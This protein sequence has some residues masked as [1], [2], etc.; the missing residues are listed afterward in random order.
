MALLF[1]RC[2]PNAKHHTL[3]V[4]NPT[5]VAYNECDEAQSTRRVPRGAGGR[6]GRRRGGN[7]RR[8]G[9][10]GSEQAAADG[11]RLLR[12]A[13]RLREDAD[14]ALRRPLRLRRLRPGRDRDR[15][16]GRHT[17]RRARSGRRLLRHERPGGGRRRAGPGQDERQDALRGRERKP[18]RGRRL[19][20]AAAAARLA[21]ARPRFDSRAVAPRRPAARPLARRLLDRAAARSHRPDR[22]LP[23]GQ[24]GPGRDGR[25]RP[26]QAPARSHARARRLLRRSAARRLERPHRRRRTGPGRAAL[27]DPDRRL[28]GGDRG[29]QASQRGRRRAL[30]GRELA[31]VLPG[32]ARGREGRQGAAARP[33]SPRPSPDLVLRVSAC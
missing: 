25:L 30:E 13:A 17:R 26:G 23:A 27:Q 6:L 21:R 8:N 4:T 9:R 20:P 15:C 14:E 12:P 28:A 1:V 2:S 31:A 22:P 18:A 33:V 11:V 24:V 5:C 3:G 32:Q 7:D 16:S 19:R 10:S 29:G